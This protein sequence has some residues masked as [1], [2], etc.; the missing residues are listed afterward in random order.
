[1]ATRI[2]APEFPDG[3]EWIGAP[4]PLRLADLRGQVVILD[5]WTYCCVNC[6]H[7]LPVLAALE[8]K[9]LDDPVVVIGVHSAKFSGEA[10]AARIRDAVG[11]YGIRHPV[12]V[13][14]DHRIWQSYTVR[15]WPTLV[16]IRPDGSI[17]A[18]APGEADLDALDA[19][20]QSVIDDAREDGTLARA[21]ARAAD[22]AGEAPPGTLAFPGKVIGLP[23]DR[24]A[25]SDSG[26]HRVL[27]LGLDGGVEVVIGSGAPGLRDGTLVDSAFQSPQGLAYDREADVLFVADTGNH[28][29]REV[30][31][32]RGRVRT[33]AGT[34][35][36]GRVVP[37]V[38]MAALA[39]PLRSPWDLV[40]AGD[41]VLVAMAGAHQIW[42]YSRAEETMG[43]FAGSGR[44]GIADG[45][46]PE[47]AFAQPSGLALDGAKLYVAD[48][49]TSAVR[50]LDLST[51]R[52]R[53][54]AGTGLF[55]FGDVDGPRETARLQ[56]PIGIAVGPAGVL[57]ADTYN[58]KVKRIDPEAGGAET[59]FE[60][61]DDL[62]LR[63]PAGLCQLDDGRIVVS[64][65]NH[66]RLVVLSAD[67]RHAERLAI[68]PVAAEA[69]VAG[70][71][72]GRAPVRT[73]RRIELG[74]GDA[75]LRLRLRP[76]EGFGLAEGSRVSIRVDAGPRFVA[77]EGD[78][79]FD[80]TGTGR[81]VPV[82]LRPADGTD[83]EGSVTI[84]LE[85][86][87]CGHGEGGACWP[88]ST[89][90]RVPF[91]SVPTS[92]TVA[93]VPLPVPDPS[94]LRSIDTASSGGYR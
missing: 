45:A 7:V 48:S 74:R 60:G 10:D 4:R 17:A 67:G 87:L 38:P 21:P 58:H 19:F 93:D 36:L 22:A 9:R 23:G 26:H 56:H 44:E 8:G 59:L 73:L 62:A 72:E 25:V 3:F 78:L 86:V 41:Y 55:D 65:T 6:M 42:T 94:N 88:V 18:V 70:A 66:H 63:E 53:T 80:V 11:R 89:S 50:C 54:L 49:E 46:F 47:A 15:S 32:D 90:Y 85:C 64:D 12:I 77:P 82:L 76:P 34:G 40:V 71:A 14:V 92:P 81:G 51:G 28:A 43:V 68:A 35:T 52:V 13:D 2:R 5:F 61:D 20:V 27:V 39:L 69:S 29:I 84:A 1:M 83:A 30:D 24:L 16:V 91:R 31:L 33:T 37:R 79:G 75:T 57:V